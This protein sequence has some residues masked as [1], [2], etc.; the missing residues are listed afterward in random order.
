MPRRPS[1][2]PIAAALSACLLAACGETARLT[3]DAGTGPRPELPA[4]NKTLIPT[5][6]IAPA[7]GWAE[8]AKP[9]VA[10]GL[11]VVPF[12]KGLSHPRWLSCCRTA[13]CWSPR[14]M[15]R[16]SPRTARA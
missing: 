11:T 2:L 12:A 3:V 9:T 4:P 6:H 7:K 10:A 5:V 8:G 13:T 16:R 15:R 1:V 14:P